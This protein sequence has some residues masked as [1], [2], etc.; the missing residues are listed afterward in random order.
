ML[1]ELIC[2]ESRDIILIAIKGI[3]LDVIGDFSHIFSLSHVLGCVHIIIVTNRFVADLLR[4]FFEILG[5][6][7]WG[8]KSPC[9]PLLLKCTWHFICLD[10][11]QN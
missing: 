5:A 2:V 9:L 3:H 4:T 10:L 8:Q 1:P 11:N 6:C 7:A